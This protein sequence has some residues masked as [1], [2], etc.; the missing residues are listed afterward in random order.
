MS[1]AFLIAAFSFF[2]GQQ[3]NMPEAVRGSPLLFVPP[4]AVLASM[5]FWI[6]RVR[7][8]KAWLR[9]PMR[10]RPSEGSAR[11]APEHA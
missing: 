9:T 6:F 7:F 8:A 10:R 3:D 1:T 5:L 4:V 11:L 2:L